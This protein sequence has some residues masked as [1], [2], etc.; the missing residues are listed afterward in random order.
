[1]N[2]QFVERDP[3]TVEIIKEQLIAAAEESFIRLGRSSQSPIIYEVLDYACALTDAEGEL[4]A[5]ANGVPGFL[6][7]LTF[8]VKAV[9]G[10]FPG[11]ILKA[12]DII[13]SND[14]YSGGGNHLSDVALIAP[15]F[16]GK[17]LIAFSVNKAHWTEVGGMAPG[18][19]TTDSTEIYQEGLQFPVIHLGRNYQLDPS[20]LDLIEA[21][22]RTPEQTLGDLFAGVGALR[23]AEKRVVEIAERYGVQVFLDAVKEILDHGERMARHCLA[24]LPKGSFFIEDWMDDDGLTEEPVYVCVGITITEDEFIADFTG[25]APQVRGPINCTRTRLYSACRAVFKSITAPKNPVNDGWFRPLKVTCPEGT[26]FTATRPAPVST[27]W[28]TGAYAV[29]LLWHALF[30]LLPDRLTSGHFLSV[31]GTSISGYDLEGRRF[32]LVEPQ[33][34][35]W[36]AGKDKDGESGLVPVGDG[37]TYIMPVEVCEA[38]YPI[39]VERYAFNIQEAGAGRFRGGFG[40]SREYRILSDSAILT[41]TFGRHRYPPWGAEG[42]GEG[43]VNGVEVIRR[44]ADRPEVWSGKLAR[45]PLEREDLVCLKTGTGGGYGSALERDPK[46]V[47]QDVF[48]GFLNI[49]QARRIYG[50]VLEEELGAIDLGATEQLRKKMQ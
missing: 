36:G 2:D 19:W 21:N 20:L 16:I 47:L 3:F 11:D 9:L 39:L 25:S 48:N 29:D 34:G 32:I 23:V 45:Y 8:A 46:L 1:M 41:T 13:I 10:K 12:G 42:G 6:G 44:E 40:L 33:A 7:T 24:G 5:Q 26:V 43:S 18:S 17:E 38:R 14:P 22:V 35:G 27:Y 15:I 31:C 4:I 50:V 30:P 28:E 37:E 49:E